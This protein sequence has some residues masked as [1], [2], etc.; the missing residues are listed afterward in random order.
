MPAHT[1]DIQTLVALAADAEG[2]AQTGA[3]E[4]LAEQ[5]RTSP[6][7]YEFEFADALDVYAAAL[8]T[9]G[10]SGLQAVSRGLDQEGGSTIMAHM[11]ARLAV[12][13]VP[14]ALQ[15]LRR[16]AASEDSFVAETAQTW[17]KNR[18]DQKP[19]SRRFRLP[20]EC[21]DEK[22]ASVRL[23]YKQGTQVFD[24]IRCPVCGARISERERHAVR[25]SGCHVL[26][27]DASYAPP[28]FSSHALR[29]ADVETWRPMMEFEMKYW[30]VAKPWI[31]GPAGLPNI[32][33]LAYLGED[34]EDE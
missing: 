22:Y 33:V 21:Y 1:E 17:L 19:P 23:W 15:L 3:I 6:E 10:E 13:H 20:P 4:V 11:A 34:D 28:M 5:I 31:A 7:S 12:G 24:W 25:C 18:F 8:L 14:G 29:L 2:Q 30:G 9:L 16:A 32:L 27:T 26:F